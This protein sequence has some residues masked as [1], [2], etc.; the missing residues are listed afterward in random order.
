MEWNKP[1]EI[2]FYKLNNKNK[3]KLKRKDYKSKGKT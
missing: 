1:L 3:S 2:Y